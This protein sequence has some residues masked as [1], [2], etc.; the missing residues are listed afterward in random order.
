MLCSYRAALRTNPSFCLRNGEGYA[1]CAP[2][3]PLCCHIVYMHFGKYPEYCYLLGA[4]EVVRPRCARITLTQMIGLIWEAFFHC[5]CTSGRGVI[6][7]SDVLMIVPDVS[8]RMSMLAFT[9]EVGSKSSTPDFVGHFLTKRRTAFAVIP[10]N[11]QT[12]QACSQCPSTVLPIC[13][14]LLANW[15]RMSNTSRVKK[16]FCKLNNTSRGTGQF[17]SSFSLH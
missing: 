12:V 8:V 13:R 6:T 1:G 9:C 14:H 16:I 15:L 5:V 4:D 11:A 7:A 17:W 2:V 3:P 10:E